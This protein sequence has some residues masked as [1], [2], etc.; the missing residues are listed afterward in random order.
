[1]RTSRAMTGKVRPM[2]L[3]QTAACCSLTFR[4]E[5]QF[6]PGPC[7]PS[8]KTR[9]WN[10]D[11]PEPG[12]SRETSVR[13]TRPPARRRTALVRPAS[14]LVG[15]IQVY[16]DEHWLAIADHPQRHRVVVAVH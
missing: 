7:P 5:T 14:A 9:S 3:N 10:F 16:A 4:R 6:P 1:M 11:R 12:R 2:R 13:E 15:L 8:N